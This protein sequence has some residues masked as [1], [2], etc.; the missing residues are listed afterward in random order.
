MVT[1]VMVNTTVP[2]ATAIQWTGIT[3]AMGTAKDVPV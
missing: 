2:S 1:P 3:G